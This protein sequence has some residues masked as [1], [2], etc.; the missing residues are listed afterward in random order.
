MKSFHFKSLINPI[1]P[2]SIFQDRAIQFVIR[3][4]KLK[5]SMVIGWYDA[6]SLA[7]LLNRII[8]LYFI[9]CE[10]SKV[11]WYQTGN[12]TLLLPV[13]LTFL[14]VK[15]RIQYLELPSFRLRSWFQGIL[16]IWFDVLPQPSDFA[17]RYAD[18][19]VTQ[20][21]SWNMGNLRALVQG[22]WLQNLWIS[23]AASTH[24]L[25]AQADH[26]TATTFSLLIGTEMH[27][28]LT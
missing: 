28:Y 9:G 12:L 19:I 22:G 7:Y 10:N 20:Q 24:H 11:S 3:P 15:T 2:V 25:S 21:A 8:L 27:S 6:R 5:G 4:Q 14:P 1:F 13:L 18:S 16:S 23:F 26:P 17:F